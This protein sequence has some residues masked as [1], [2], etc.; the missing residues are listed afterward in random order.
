[1]EKRK[2]TLRKRA[3]Q[4]RET[5]ERIV[6]AAIAL[7]EEL[8]PA[9][10]TISD[11]AKRAGVQRLTVYRHFPDETA[12]LKAC[13]S[14]WFALNPPPDP[15]A[16]PDAEPVERVRAM[17]TAL[18]AYYRKTQTMWSSLYRDLETTPAL[19]GPMSQ[20]DSY[21]SA[22]EGAL[23]AGWTSKPSRKLRATVR[24]VLRFST[25]ESLAQQRLG[26]QAITDLACEW[27][28]VTARAGPSSER[29]GP[30]GGSRA[31]RS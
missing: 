2:Y 11:L 31:R 3:D 25:W 27:I 19:A 7:H 28:E 9:A 30:P 13:S 5:R 8:G 20:F 4:Q 22:V 14:K 15:T 17:L 6:D 1:M 26:Q 16:L 29:Y 12:I 21:L 10:T 24:H 23:L 18:Y